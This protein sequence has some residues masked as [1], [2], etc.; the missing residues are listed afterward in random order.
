MNTITSI[1]NGEPASN[2]S[3]ISG[4]QAQVSIPSS[5]GQ[6]PSGNPSSNYLQLLSRIAP[7][8]RAPLTSPRSQTEMEL[9]IRTERIL[10]LLLLQPP[11]IRNQVLQWLDPGDL[12]HLRATCHAMHDFVHESERAICLS[13]RERIAQK[14]DISDAIINVPDLSAFFR[15]S[16]QYDCVCDVATITAERITRFLKCIGHSDDKSALETWRARKSLRLQKKLV[17]SFIYLQIYLDYLVDTITK[18]EEILSH[19]DDD[20]YTTLHHVFDLD[21]QQFLTNQ[22]ASLT[23]RDFIDITAALAIF[24]SVC[25]AR[26]V[27]FTFKSH[28]HP[29]TSVRQI[30][31]YKGLAPFAKMLAKDT[32]LAQQDVLLRRISREI[33]Q[34]RR[35]FLNTSVQAESSYSIHPL[36]GYNRNRYAY[37]DPKRS[38]KARDTFISH[39]D[40]WDRSARAFMMRKLGR[41]PTLQ[42]STTWIA[43]V[44]AEEERDSHIIVGPWD[45]PDRG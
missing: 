24:K 9:D 38:S 12:L 25:K 20:E 2:H 28:M 36:E 45:M 22:M 17:R 1:S 26:C 31:V 27:P 32:G 3:N 19:L 14:H 35:S 8:L 40:I 44:V 10:H 23:E 15:L 13:L 42:S 34:F 21:Q 7:A 4:P 11:E 6:T 5:H 43:N 30:L 39:Q 41:Y 16:R 18:N 29:F 37:F 33:G